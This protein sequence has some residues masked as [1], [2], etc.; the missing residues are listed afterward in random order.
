MTAVTSGALELCLARVFDW[1]NQ[2]LWSNP[3]VISYSRP[4]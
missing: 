2:P 4:V 3:G 1:W